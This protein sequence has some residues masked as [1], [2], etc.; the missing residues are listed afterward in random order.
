MD[1]VTAKLR[2]LLKASSPLSDAGRRM[3]AIA[4][5][6]SVQSTY[7]EDALL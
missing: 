5:M 3:L 1:Q 4:K 2:I 6:G 7:G